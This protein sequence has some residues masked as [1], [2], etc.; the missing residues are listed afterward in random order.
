MTK[1]TALMVTLLC[2]APF[3]LA[4][5]AQASTAL[6]HQCGGEQVTLLGTDGPDRLVGTPG[7]DVIWGG[8]GN[9]IIRGGGGD[10]VVC[11]GA[12]ADVVMTGL[13]KR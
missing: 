12:G 10:D 9:D 11:A 13:A 6:A 3:P 1:L 4:S 8:P 7:A 2:C 5:N